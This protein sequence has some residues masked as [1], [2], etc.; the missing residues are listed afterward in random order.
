MT[1]VQTCALPICL[2]EA[3]EDLADIRA[4]DA[5][6]PKV[7]AEKKIGQVASLSEYRRLR[8]K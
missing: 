4:Y 2:R 5:A 8:K 3:E 6:R 7:L 1:G